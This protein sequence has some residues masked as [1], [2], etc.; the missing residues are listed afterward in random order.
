[1]AGTAWLWPRMGEFLP[2]GI[3]TLLC[4]HILRLYLLLH[5]STAAATPHLFSLYN[6]P[7]YDP[8]CQGRKRVLAMRRP[9]R[10]KGCPGALTVRATPPGGHGRLRGH[11]QPGAAGDRGS[12]DVGGALGGVQPQGGP[13]PETGGNQ[14]WIGVNVVLLRQ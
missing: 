13:Q 10:P 3:K 6:E 7:P 12:V 14:V 1:M 8:P 9:R 4:L 2:G 5:Q 11:A